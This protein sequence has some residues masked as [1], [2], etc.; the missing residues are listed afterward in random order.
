MCKITGACGWQKFFWAGQILYSQTNFQRDFR[1]VSILGFNSKALSWYSNF[2]SGFRMKSSIYVKR[3][4]FEG[5]RLKYANFQSFL[6]FWSFFAN[7][8]YCVTVLVTF[9]IAR[10]Q[11][12]Y[13][14]TMNISFSYAGRKYTHAITKNSTNLFINT[15]IHGQIA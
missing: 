5:I 12:Y 4:L 11:A 8:R 15:N 2:P 10:V 6:L 14:V 13:D 7:H 1:Q 9:A 3:Q